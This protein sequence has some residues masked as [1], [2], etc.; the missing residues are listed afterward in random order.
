MVPFICHHILITSG[1]LFCECIYI[2]T[3][4][5]VYIK[6]CTCFGSTSIYI[7]HWKWAQQWFWHLNDKINGCILWI[8]MRWWIS[9][10]SHI[11]VYNVYIIY[12]GICYQINYLTIQAFYRS[13]ISNGSSNV[14]L[15]SDL[16]CNGDVPDNWINMSDN[17]SS[18]CHSLNCYQPYSFICVLPLEILWYLIYWLFFMLSW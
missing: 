1:C 3:Y 10:W 13:C 17:L 5:C 9:S 14:T 8:L 12:F 2:Y 15:C 11:S 4:N 7:H 6:V 16:Y 18:Y